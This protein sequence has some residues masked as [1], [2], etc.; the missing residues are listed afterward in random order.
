MT[1]KFDRAGSARTDEFGILKT[2][3]EVYGCLVRNFQE[4]ST[5]FLKFRFSVRIDNE[6]VFSYYSPGYWIL[7]KAP[8]RKKLQPLLNAQRSM[9]N[10]LR[11][12][13]CYFGDIS[14]RLLHRPENKIT[15]Q[16]PRHT[17]RVYYPVIDIE[18]WSA[19][20]ANEHIARCMGRVSREI[21]AHCEERDECETSAESQQE[22]SQQEESPTLNSQMVQ[23]PMSN[24]SDMRLYNQ[25]PPT[26]SIIGS[27]GQLTFERVNMEIPRSAQSYTFTDLMQTPTTD[28]PRIQDADKIDESHDT[29]IHN[30]F[31]DTNSFFL[32]EWDDEN[33]FWE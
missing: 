28:Q 6:E 14:R 33:S 4:G 16:A 31:L 19:A 21:Q 13:T 24:P 25:T 30:S 20:D 1:A 18:T 22:E 26:P 12:T 10:F 32:S 8:S 9:E 23:S 7:S 27:S 3:C 11:R 5:G 29:Q 2:S 17:I 15:S